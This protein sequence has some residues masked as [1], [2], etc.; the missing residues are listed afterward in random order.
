MK[1]KID[2]VIFENIF[3]SKLRSLAMNVLRIPKALHDLLRPKDRR[4]ELRV[5]HNWG[6]VIPYLSYTILR[7]Y[8]FTISHHLFPRCV[9]KR[10]G[11]LEV[12]WQLG[13]VE[14]KHLKDQ[15]KGTF[16]P[17]YTCFSNFVMIKGGWNNINNILKTF[18]MKRER[19]RE[20]HYSEG[21]I[22]WL[23]LGTRVPSLSTFSST[24]RM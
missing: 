14:N 4:L 1:K 13:S 19:V 23:K 5:D 22:A 17:S 3:A 11:F 21:F 10:I 18:H 20:Y 16:F 24:L 8:G 12:M 9:P 2:F 7:V 6:D 15:G